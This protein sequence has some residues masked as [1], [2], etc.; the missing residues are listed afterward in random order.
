VE[1]RDGKTRFRGWLDAVRISWD[2]QP[3]QGAKDM[4]SS[5]SFGK[6]VGTEEGRR[7]N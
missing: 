6:R 4:Q 2:G 1:V 3:V 5:V 7:G